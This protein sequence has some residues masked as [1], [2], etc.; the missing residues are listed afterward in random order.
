[1]SYEFSYK[2]ID[3]GIL[4]KVGPFGIVKMISHWFNQLKHLQSG[5]IYHYLFLMFISM[6]FLLWLGIFP[7]SLLIILNSTFFLSLITFFFF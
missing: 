1:M 5:Y 4:E 3:R 7:N 2:D 6:L